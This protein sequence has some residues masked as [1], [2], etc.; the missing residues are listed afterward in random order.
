MKTPAK[1][2][3]HMKWQTFVLGVMLFLTP[4]VGYGFGKNKVQYFSYQWKIFSHPKFD[5]YF[6]ENQ[7]NIVQEISSLI[8]EAYQHHEKLFG[9]TLEKKIT[10]ILYPNQID[11]FKNNVLPWTKRGTEG[12]TEFSRGRVVLYHTPN[13]EEMRHFT[14]HELAHVFQL[15]LWNKEKKPLQPTFFSIPLWVIEGAAE[16]ASVGATKEGDRYV[17]NLLYRGKVPTLSELGRPY[18]LQPY[19]YYLVYK[20]GALFYAY[21]TEKWG[22]DFFKRLMRAVATYGDWKK[23][24]SEELKISESSLDREFREYL[25]QRYFPLYPQS[26]LALRLHDK[27]QFESHIVWISSNEFITMGVDRYYPSYILYNTKTKKRTVLSRTGTSEQNLFFQYQRNHLSHSQNNLVCWLIEGGDRY[28][29]VIYNTQ[30]RKTTTHE[31]PYRIFLSPEISPD[32]EEVVFVG[33]DQENHVLAT[34]NLITKTTE[35]LVKSRHVINFPRWLDKEH[36]IVAANFAHGEKSDNLDLYLYDRREKKWLWR[37]DSGDSDEMPSVVMDEGHPAILFVQQSLFPQ[38]ILYDITSE[39]G[40]PLY[41]ACGE[42]SFPVLENKTL[43]FTLY[44][45]GSMALYSLPLQQKTAISLP[46]EKNPTVIVSQ[47]EPIP[48]TRIT[49]YTWNMAPDSLFFVF[50]INSTGAGALSGFFIGSDVLGDHQL[51][52]LADSIFTGS[53]PKLA[54]WNFEVEYNILKYRPQWAWRVLHYNNLFFEWLQFPDFYRVEKAYFEKWQA[55]STVQYPFSSFQRI[56]GGVSFRS[57]SFITSL[58]QEGDTLTIELARKMEGIVSLAYIFDNTLES[59]IGPMDGIRALVSV[60]QSFPFNNLGSFAT[61]LVADIRGYWMIFPGYNFASRLVTGTIVN[62]TSENKKFFYGGGFHSIRGYPYGTFQGDVM[63][64]VNTEF[65]F[66]LIRYWEIGFPP[67]VLPTIWSTLFWDMG[68]FAQRN[69]LSSFQGMIE[70][71]GTMQFH[72]IHMSGGIGF[73]I[74][75]GGDIKLMWNIAYPFNGVIFSEP[76]HEIVLTRDF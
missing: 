47:T 43:F 31:L 45:D 23:I 50:G 17:A 15:A 36:I 22:K 74:A 13:Q 32:G 60:E 16:W 69:T 12:F 57:L 73:R 20:E 19:Q 42:V 53:N 5:F 46:L 27:A 4:F 25:S 33:L 68:I 52:I 64:V 29:L 26:T 7:T 1:E 58:T 75:F 9:I 56:E 35:V 2:K 38:I 41:T 39:T 44:D 34:Y 62:Y 48:F 72:D 3:T 28:R 14:Y 76:I 8:E 59:E 21:A 61:T 65:R 66:P 11:F 51:F 6:T 54:G 49:K 10:I 37:L 18:Q 24:L 70:Q 40:Y 67:I 55:D 30:S 71:N 63:G